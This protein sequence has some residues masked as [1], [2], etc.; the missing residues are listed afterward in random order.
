MAGDRDALAVVEVYI[1]S[2]NAA[3]A[4]L[5]PQRRVD[6]ELVARWKT[7]LLAS[8]PHRWWVAELNGNI[9][10]FAG[11]CPSRDPVD[12]HLGELDTIAV[13]P[14]M[15]LHGIGRALMANALAHLVRDGY[16]EAVLWTWANYERGRIFYEK[17]GWFLDG[18]KR[19]DGRQVL[20]RHQ[21]SK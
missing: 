4:G 20:Y 17:T 7:D 12:P 19:Y 6:A 10:G 21:L 13:A 8:L 16:G 2:W 3:F 9:V 11:I 18:R 15:W 5:A 14:T 1:G